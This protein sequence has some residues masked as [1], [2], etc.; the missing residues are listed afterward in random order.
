MGSPWRSVNRASPAHPKQ[1]RTH[2]SAA[3]TRRRAPCHRLAVA[4]LW[5]QRIAMRRSGPHTPDA[6]PPSKRDHMRKRDHARQAERRPWQRRDEAPHSDAVI[7]YGWHT[8]KAALDN[9]TRRIRHLYATENAAR[10]L[11]AD[12]VAPA[13]APEVVRPDAIARRL[14]SAAVHN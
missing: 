5:R 6:R 11:A 10:R 12:G 14:G 2:A 1:S 3:S 13:V 8:V 7:L 4:G 9:P